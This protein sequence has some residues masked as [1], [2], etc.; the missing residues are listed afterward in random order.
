M[1]RY[2]IEHNYYGVLSQDTDFYI[3]D[4]PRYLPLW[5]LDIKD[6]GTN[7][8]IRAKVFESG[9]LAKLF[10]FNKKVSTCID[11]EKH[12]KTLSFCFQFLPLF[13][14]LVGNDTTFMHQNLIRQIYTALKVKD[15]ESR[16]QVI[17]AVGGLLSTASNRPNTEPLEVVSTLLKNVQPKIRCKTY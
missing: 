3:Y 10:K 13:A 9:A 12:P 4:V 17:R 16:V 14:S 6:D 1:A 8:T 2:C 11:F 15:W 7:T 5:M